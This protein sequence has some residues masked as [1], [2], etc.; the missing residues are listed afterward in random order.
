MSG[1]IPRQATVDQEPQA[2][3]DEELAALPFPD[4]QIS[5]LTRT[6]RHEVATDRT[7]WI[8]TLAALVS[9][10]QLSRHVARRSAADLAWAA[11]EAGQRYPND[12]DWS[13][14]SEAADPVMARRVLA[15]VHGYRLRF[16][17]RFDDLAA[18]TREWMG[19]VP[20]DALIQSF[21]AFAALGQRSDRAEHLLRRATAAADYDLSCRAVCLHGLWLA[22]HLPDQADRIIALSDEM[23][24]KGEDG[25]NLYYWRSFALRRK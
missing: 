1:D 20:D 6:L 3:V 15:Y 13:R 22:D 24:S 17:F 19:L 16:D 11:R 23:I 21:A 2:T 14:C 10:H 25:A 7:D 4:Q 12:A 9:R 8:F 18:R 5:F